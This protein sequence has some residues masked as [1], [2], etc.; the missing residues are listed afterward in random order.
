MN[1]LNNLLGDNLFVSSLLGVPF[2]PEA[3][4]ITP[5]VRNSSSIRKEIRRKTTSK[6]DRVNSKLP[7]E[8]SSVIS[9]E[10]NRSRV[11]ITPPIVNQKVTVEVPKKK[12]I[13]KPK[14]QEYTLEKQRV[15]EL[16]QKILEE[17]FEL[18]EKTELSYNSLGILFIRRSGI[19]NS[20]LP[21]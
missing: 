2:K 3:R 13:S 16:L 9:E 6:S 4:K 19:L 8:K 10:L 5:K 20:K 14:Q 17:T 15:Q 11:E 21:V 12:E 18:E 7:S 1:L